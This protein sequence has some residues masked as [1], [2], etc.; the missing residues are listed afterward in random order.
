MKEYDLIIIGSG[1]GTDILEAAVEHGLKTALIDDGPAGGTCLNVGCIPS[2]MLIFPADRI[3]EVREAA[4]LGIDAEI[5]NIDFALIMDR[6]RR[7]VEAERLHVEEQLKKSR[8][9]DYYTETAEFVA[10]NTLKVG[11]RNLKASLIYL[12]SGSRPLIPPIP[13]LDSVKYLTNETLLHLRELPKSLI[14]IGG[15]YVGVEYAHFFQAMGSDVTLVE[16]GPRLVPSEEPE[17]SELLL[18][19]LARR[20]EV[21]VNSVAESVAQTDFGGVAVR[22]LNQENNRSE[23]ITA[24][25]L[26]IAA[27]RRSN[28]DRLKVEKSGIKTDDKGFICVNAYLETS[29]KGIYAIGDANGREMFT[30]TSHAEAAVAAANG[31]HGQKKTMNYWA[32][33]HAVF[34]HPQIASVGLTENAARQKYKVAVGRADYA[35]IAL[36]GA[37][38]QREGFA[39]IVLEQE[40]GKILGG[41]VI[42]PWASVVIQEVINVMARRGSAEDIGR[43]IHIHPALSELIIK[44]VYNAA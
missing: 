33:P 41:H 23:T 21:R 20:L 5:T 19:S 37:M 27:G 25:K 40:T 7:L 2:K 9:L 32:A 28:S 18:S 39:K 11:G 42:G 26:L 22:V 34:T 24:D 29:V 36:G 4:R 10:R 6:S 31:I 16:M 30:H 17:I 38:M 3:I 14:I 44:A 43:G 1:A 15:G 35:D 13:G 8:A 12:A